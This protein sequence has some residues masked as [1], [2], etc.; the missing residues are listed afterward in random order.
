MKVSTKGRYALRLMIDLA[1]NQDEGRQSLTSISKRQN[2]S[3]KYLEQ[4]VR[5]YNKA[6]YIKRTR[7]A[8]GGYE[9]AKP[10][11]EYIIGDILR[12]AEGPLAPT[13]C[14]STP[15][16]ECAH[17]EKCSTIHFWEGLRDVINN[18]VDSVTLADLVDQNGQHVCLHIED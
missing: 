11:S 2:I 4:L 10:A 15:T 16:N 6:G 1:Q 12:V 18:Y 9:L 14:L 8:Q 3:L 17:Y 13:S 5:L 7:G